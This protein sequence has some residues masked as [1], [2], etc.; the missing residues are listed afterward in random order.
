MGRLIF[1]VVLCSG[2]SRVKNPS[3]FRDSWL[4]VADVAVFGARW[5]KAFWMA[6]AIALI[7]TRSMPFAL[8]MTP[9]PG[10]KGGELP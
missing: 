3:L 4:D 7:S 2:L 5:N 6:F 10:A 8:M 9:V 1:F